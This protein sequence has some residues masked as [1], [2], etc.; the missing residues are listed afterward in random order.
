MVGMPIKKFY[1]EGD[2][3]VI[4]V[5]LRPSL[6][7]IG[8]SYNLKVHTK[9]L[10]KENKVEVIVSGGEDDIQR[11]WNHVENVDV[12]PTKDK[13]TYGV[14]GLE[15]YEGVEPDWSY[16][17]NASVMEQIYKGVSRLEGIEGG[18]GALAGVLQQ[19]LQGIDMK[20]GEMI[21]RFGVFGSYAK[22]MD[23]KLDALPKRIAD[24]M[25]RREGTS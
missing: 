18:L 20:F 1:I 4:D 24:A 7:A 16:H 17:V 12:R 3:K 22:A 15:P 2:G 23:E 21:D 10:H 5:G 6:V 13:G 8:L 14:S 11:F 9:N 25:N 19:T